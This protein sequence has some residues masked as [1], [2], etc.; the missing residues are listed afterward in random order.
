L[1][2][3][4]VRTLAADGVSQREIVRERL[5]R[6]ADGCSRP[7]GFEDRMV[8]RTAPPRRAG[9]RSVSAVMGHDLGQ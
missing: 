6:L 2:W 4:E 8:L 3:A 9:M 5:N 1:E 7:A